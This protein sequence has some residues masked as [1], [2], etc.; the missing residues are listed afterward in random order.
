MINSNFQFVEVRFDMV[1]Y[2]RSFAVNVESRFRKI[3]EPCFKIH[4]RKIAG[5]EKVMNVVAMAGE[6]RCE[7]F[8]HRKCGN[9][10]YDEAESAH[11]LRLLC[12]FLLL[13]FQSYRTLSALWNA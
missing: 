11:F 1:E 7:G 13:Q 10:I 12:D 6:S 8:L 2:R 9:Q 4:F 3:D 5:C